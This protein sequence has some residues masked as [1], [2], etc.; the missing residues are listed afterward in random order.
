MKRRTLCPPVLMN[1]RL[2]II[3]LLI[4]TVLSLV[5][6]IDAVL[7]YTGLFDSDTDYAGWSS[8]K[9]SSADIV[10]S[11]IEQHKVGSDV[12]TISRRQAWQLTTV[13]LLYCKRHPFMAALIGTI[14]IILAALAITLILYL[15][16]SA[17]IRVD[18]EEEE[19][20]G[21]VGQRSA[22]ASADSGVASVLAASLSFVLLCA[23]STLAWFRGKKF[24][25]ESDETPDGSTDEFLVKDNAIVWVRKKG[26]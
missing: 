21:E 5:F 18:Y 11:Q 20:I 1:P 24:V 14:L 6:A 22:T 15:R 26:S 8:S 25:E 12:A 4:F 19:S 23:V 10:N 3:F 9:T 17:M 13:F 16:R 7:A 2:A